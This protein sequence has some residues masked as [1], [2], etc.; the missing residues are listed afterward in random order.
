MGDLVEPDWKPEPRPERQH[1][2]LPARRATARRRAHPVPLGGGVDV[3]LGLIVPSM[4]ASY[5]V[6]AAKDDF[7][8]QVAA[9]AGGRCQVRI[10]PDCTGDGQHAHHRW[11]AGQ[12]GPDTVENG[13]WVCLLCHDWIHFR[14]VDWARRHLWIV[15]PGH[16]LDPPV[17]C[18]LDCDEDHRPGVAA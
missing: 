17:S 9:A 6:A 11:R 12:G 1:R 13:R 7:R 5:V 8:R 4:A 3:A 2:P 10:H 18:G 15:S 16:P 14:F